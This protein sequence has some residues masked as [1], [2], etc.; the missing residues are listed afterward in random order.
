MSHGPRIYNLFPLLVGPIARWTEDIPRIRRMGFDWIYVN[1]FH[2][3]GFSGSLYAVKDYRRLNPLFGDDESAL[4]DFLRAAA[5]AGVRV[6]MDLVINHTGKDALLVDE[7]PDWYARTP[8]GALK[9]PGAV[10]PDDPAK[11]TEWGDL[12]EL[13]YDDPSL[14]PAMIEHWRRMVAD[15]ARMGFAGFRCDAAYKVPSAVWAGLIGGVRAE[16]PKTVFAAETLGCKTEEIAALHDAGF[17]LLFN[18]AK[19]WDFHAPWLL[20]Q[21]DLLRSIAPSVAFP[22]SHDTERLA[23][24]GEGDVEARLKQRALFSAFFSAGWMMPVGYEWG[25]RGKLDVVT[26]RPGD[27]EDTGI[28]ISAFIG[29][30]NAVKAAARVL[31]EEGPQHRLTDPGAAVAALLRLTPD[32]GEAG[33]LVIN[34]DPAHAHAADPARMLTDAGQDAGRFR[35][36]LTTAGAGGDLAP[37]EARLFLTE[38]AKEATMGEQSQAPVPAVRRPGGV[39]ALPDVHS[40]GILILDVRPVVDCGRY[41]VKREAGDVLEVTADILK[42]GH[43]KIGRAHV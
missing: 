32:G 7:H 26:T 31:N 8:D 15:Y 37:L 28:D 27:R 25:Y 43:D 14:H 34:T 18:S 4:G 2:Y 1:P 19:W 9:S 21:Y 40:P 13:D 6:M 17:D 16:F 41:P 11:V 33:L 12:A 42:D 10:D 20:E 23:A 36:A 24:E 38:T 30:V 39:G 5:G 22:E 35:L 3:P 29:R